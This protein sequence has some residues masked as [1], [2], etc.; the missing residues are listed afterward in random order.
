[1]DFSKLKYDPRVKG[2][3]TQ[4]YPVMKGRFPEHKD[5]DMLIRFAIL[6]L[7]PFS[8][9]AEERDIEVK[10]RDA[11]KALKEESWS[12]FYKHV[13]TNDS[14]WGDVVYGYFSLIHHTQ[15]ETWL[16]LKMSFHQLSQELRGI[17]DSKDRVAA[18]KGLASI[19]QEII[20]LEAKLFPDEY[21]K[22]QII[23]KIPL[24]GYAERF[25]LYLN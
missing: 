8:P 21:T 18:S 9:I 6:F 23:E 17:M 2:K 11:L 22:H 1:M 4:E 3:I 5:V 19:N 15:Y 25:A 10:K 12:D 20:E 24:A 14:M 16:T 13:E 7:D